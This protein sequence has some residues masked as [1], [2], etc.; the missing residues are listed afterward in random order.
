M[1]ICPHIHA[2]CNPTEHFKVSTLRYAVSTSTLL[3]H[4]API[5]AS[6]IVDIN[7]AYLLDPFMRQETSLEGWCRAL[8]ALQQHH[9]ISSTKNYQKSRRT[10]CGTSPQ[11]DSMMRDRLEHAEKAVAG[12][13]SLMMPHTAINPTPYTT[14]TDYF[15]IIEGWIKE[16][17]IEW[18]PAV[19]DCYNWVEGVGELLE[20]LMDEGE[21]RRDRKERTAGVGTSGM[22]LNLGSGSEKA[23][24]RKAGDDLTIEAS[25][26]KR[27]RNRKK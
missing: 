9:P 23:G 6:G 24:K 10:W 21:R 25:R 20:W 1:N 16:G 5:I 17:R 19:G 13:P 4:T 15:A 2:Q 22:G 3:E 14:T 12:V 26:G 27:R 11:F 7:L 18:R 8:E